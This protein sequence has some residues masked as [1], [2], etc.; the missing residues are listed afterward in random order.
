MPHY[1][2]KSSLFLARKVMKTNSSTH[3]YKSAAWTPSQIARLSVDFKRRFYVTKNRNMMRFSSFPPIGLIRRNKT[4][5]VK[6][7]CHGFAI[8]NREEVK[9]YCITALTLGRDNRTNI[10]CFQLCSCSCGMGS[11]VSWCRSSYNR[12]RPFLHRMTPAAK[13]SLHLDQSFLPTDRHPS[14]A[15]MKRLHGFDLSLD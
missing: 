10:W 3:R 14:R 15:T 13:D 8:V 2:I 5:I 4:N 12:I 7:N 9:T 1:L 11:F 6:M